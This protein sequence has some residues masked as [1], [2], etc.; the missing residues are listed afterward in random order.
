MWQYSMFFEKHS[1]SMSQ[2]VISL[3]KSMTLN[4]IYSTKGF[5]FTIHCTTI[6]NNKDKAN[7]DSSWQ[8]RCGPINNCSI[9]FPR[10]KIYICADI[11]HWNHGSKGLHLAC[12][13]KLYLQAP[14]GIVQDDHFAGLEIFVANF[15]NDEYGMIHHLIRE[16]L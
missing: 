8:R 13:Y 16:Y 12:R 5:I 4:Y 14:K 3:S 9:W 2:Y 6:Y 7:T 11:Y 10:K 1:L 15:F